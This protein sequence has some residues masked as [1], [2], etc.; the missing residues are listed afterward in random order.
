MDIWEKRKA[1]KAF[2][3]PS[4]EW[5]E[6]TMN[7]AEDCIEDKSYGKPLVKTGLRAHGENRKYSTKQEYP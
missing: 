3:T 1:H 2:P 6:S 4:S 7:I 5:W